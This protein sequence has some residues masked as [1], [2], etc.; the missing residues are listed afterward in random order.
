MR[1]RGLRRR[2]SSPKG[3]GSKLSNLA[4]ARLGG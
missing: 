4:V 2:A 3:L 1:A